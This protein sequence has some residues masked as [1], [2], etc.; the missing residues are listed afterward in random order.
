MKSLKGLVFLVL[1]SLAL[2]PAA[3]PQD[4]AP[5]EKGSEKKGLT[6]LHKSLLVPGWGQAS[7]GRYVE[8]AVFFASELVTLYE[9]FRLSRRGS[10]DYARYKAAT[11]TE[12]ALKYR[13]LTIKNDKKRNQ[14]MLA[15]AGVW[16]LN[17]LHV[18]LVVR[19]KEKK[20]GALDVKLNA[21]NR[22]EIS[23]SLS[24]SY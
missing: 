12:D 22:Q 14:W 18:S 4:P 6:S 17:L 24:Y 8:G 9:I 16:A 15:A 20:S 23:F 3:Y 11:T 7:E 10:K 21:K 1:L 13:E 19:H 2:S 5:E